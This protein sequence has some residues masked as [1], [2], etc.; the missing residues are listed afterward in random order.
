MAPAA[1]S[2]PTASPPAAAPSALGRRFRAWFE[3]R[4]LGPADVPLAIF[5]HEVLG[6]AM[7]ASLWSACYYTRPTRT[8]AR[9]LLLLAGDS[10]AQHAQAIY[11]AA[12]AQASATLRRVSWRGGVAGKPAMGAAP[13]RDVPRLTAALA[14]S[15]CIR[16]I[17][18]FTF[19]SCGRRCRWY[20]R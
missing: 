14:E 13:A 2:P 3:D 15:L 6:L 8:L 11:D 1:A 5:M 10:S 9:P 12:M 20:S 18:P 17:K 7:A 4:G 16:A 19:V